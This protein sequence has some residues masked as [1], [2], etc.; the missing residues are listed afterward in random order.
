MN[1]RRHLRNDG[2]TT[3]IVASLMPYAIGAAVL[4]AAG[5]Y[6]YQ[7]FP[8]FAK[9]FGG[10]PAQQP[11]GND[12]SAA[13]TIGALISHPSDEISTLSQD[14]SDSVSGVESMAGDAVTAAENGIG[15][16]WANL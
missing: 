9:L 13:T 11:G 7:N 8:W 4:G 10:T 16:L 1:R 2:V 3:A 12:T 14:V 5:F 6:A 15:Q